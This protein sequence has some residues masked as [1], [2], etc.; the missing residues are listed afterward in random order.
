MPLGAVQRRAKA[1]L[2]LLEVAATMP[3]R[4]ADDELDPVG[5]A[6]PHATVQHDGAAAPHVVAR[7]VQGDVG[8]DP[9]RLVA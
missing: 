9:L 5:A 8:V 6:R 1:P 2:R 4:A 7:H 3:A